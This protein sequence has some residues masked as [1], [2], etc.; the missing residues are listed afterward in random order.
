MLWLK[1]PEQ[2]THE[3]FDVEHLPV[4]KEFDLLSFVDLACVKAR[5]KITKKGDL[6]REAAELLAV[7]YSNISAFVIRSALWERE[8][9]QNTSVGNGV[10]IPHATLAQAG[11]ADSAIAIL[12]TESPIE[13]G[14]SNQRKVD[15]FF[16]T[17]GSPENRQMHLKILAELSRIC[18]KT[19]FLTRARAAESKGAIMEA[20]RACLSDFH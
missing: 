16:V 20:F 4:E 7:H 2:R 12:T 3:A 19:D 6:F 1:N 5:L 10:A 11:N 14:E 13:Y 18:L 8:Q 17:T 15:V 9:L